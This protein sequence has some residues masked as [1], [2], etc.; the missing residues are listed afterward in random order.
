MKHKKF[1]ASLFHRPIRVYLRLSRRKKKSS[2]LHRR[3][4][5]RPAH[6][7]TK[8]Q[9]GKNTAEIYIISRSSSRS[10]RLC[11]WRGCFSSNILFICFISFSLFVVSLSLS[12]DGRVTVSVHDNDEAALLCLLMTPRKKSIVF[13]RFPAALFGLISPSDYNSGRAKRYY[14][15]A[16]FFM[17]LVFL[18]R[19]FRSFFEC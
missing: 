10:A 17:F 7:Q 5:K 11:K 15:I 16:T 1:F 6:T 9:R 8:R 12:M 4:K 3:G 19:L 14:I 2:S 13:R 18:S